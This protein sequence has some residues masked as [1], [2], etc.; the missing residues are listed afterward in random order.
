MIF[1]SNQSILEPQR[2]LESYNTSKCVALGVDKTVWIIWVK[3]F[4]IFYVNDALPDF[5]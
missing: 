4:C 3:F 1:F 5:D 2:K